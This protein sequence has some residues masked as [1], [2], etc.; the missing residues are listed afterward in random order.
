MAMGAGPYELAGTDFGMVFQPIVRLDTQ[1]VVAHEALMRPHDGQSPL[2]LLD[3]ARDL[4]RLGEL[5]TLAVRSATSSFDFASGGLLFVNLSVHAVLQNPRRPQQVLESLQSSGHDLRRFVIEITERDIVEDS[6]R[7]AHALGFLRAAGVR[8]ALDDFGNGHSN[9]ELWHELAPEFVKLDR[10]LVHRI[11]ESGGRLSIVKAL[12]QVAESLGT[13]LV[14]EGVEDGQDLRIVQDLGIPYAQGYLLGRPNAQIALQASSEAFRTEGGKLPV[15]P[16]SA[17]PNSFRR[18]T[19]EHLM[20]EAP[21]LR[22]DASNTDAEQL[23]RNNPQLPALPVVDGHGVPLGL[24]NRRVFNERMA[25]P[26]ARELSGRKPCTLHMH[27]APVVCDVGQSIDAMSEILLGEDQ[28]YLSDGFIIVEGG[29]YRG[30]GASEALVRRVT[31][32]RIEAARYAN[33][34]TLLPGNIPITEHIGRLLEGKQEFA[35]AYCD[36]NSFKPFND[37]YGYFRG[38]RMIQL[39]ATTLARHA[40]PRWDFVGHVGGD[41]FVVLLQS[42]D[43]QARCERVVA[44]FN[45]A[46][47]ALFDPEDVAR[48]V[49]EGEDRSGRYATFALTTLA[50]GVVHPLPGQFTSAEEIASLAASA[51]RQAKRQQ[52]GV[53][54]LSQ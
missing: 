19:A 37:Q 40:D 6:G 12:V 9:F 36:L 30:V 35:A 10:Y 14:A 15:M 33:P 51:K 43:W 41:D 29:R 50:I 47:M 3:A 22:D 24:L 17:R 2:A 38:D 49:L 54:V 39:V 44:E 16:R 23:F 25:M 32:L 26:F 7:L 28:R 31:E 5:E 18:I 46:A 52:R 48:G 21:C 4:G 53:F 34:L 13:E 42:E 11:A 8:I 45:A 20:I 1:R 27:T